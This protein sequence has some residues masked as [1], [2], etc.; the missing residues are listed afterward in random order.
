MIIDSVNGSIETGGFPADL[1]PLTEF[2]PL[3]AL[4]RIDHCTQM[5][6]LGCY[7]ALKDADMI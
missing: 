5:A 4:R 6:L 2:I 7:L 1:S 3:K